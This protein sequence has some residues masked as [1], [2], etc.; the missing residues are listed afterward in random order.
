M[1]SN[2][3]S[4][5]TGRDQA[6]FLLELGDLLENGFSLYEGI[7]FSLIHAK[8]KYHHG[9]KDALDLLKDGHTFREFL[10]WLDFDQELVGLVSYG[11]KHG[12]LSKSLQEGGRIWLK[13]S[14]DRAKL[15]NL[16]YYPIFLLVFTFA[17]LQ[18]FTNYLLPK[19]SE[20]YQGV[21]QETNIYL[22]ISVLL[23]T[24]I[25][26]L[27]LILFLLISV[28]TLLYHYYLKQLP[29]IKQ[30][31]LMNKIPLLRSFR[32]LSITYYF[33]M[34]FGSLLKGGVSIIDALSI[35]NQQDP[36]KLIREIAFQM[37]EYLQEG[38]ELERI[39]ADT[40]VFKRDFQRIIS[41]GQ[42]NG[43]LGEELLYYSKT[44]LNEME[45]KTEKYIKVVQP[46]MFGIVAILVIL[47]YLAILM[48]MI[49]LM[50][51]I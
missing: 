28:I 35:M 15:K 34:Q 32:R 31:L 1:R 26:N 46:S 37:I 12:Q 29:K 7:E 14:E 50:N 45:M 43:L 11:E 24:L 41:H 2:Q 10:E 39:C 5:W 33:S 22:R 23:A 30:E 18:A 8:K 51:T 47:L 3:K 20:M 19:F 40:K 16:L 27:P 49:S 6:R 21:G 25:N 38:E 17:L 9:I 36:K 48:P 44:L 42:K 13:K 4:R